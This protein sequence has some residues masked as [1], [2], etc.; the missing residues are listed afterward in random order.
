MRV[1]IQFLALLEHLDWELFDHRPY[2]PALAPSDYH[3]F[4]CLKNW[5]RSQL[6]NNNEELMEGIKPCLS[7]QAADF[8]ET[9]VQKLIPQYKYLNSGGDYIEK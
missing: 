4:I 2:S 7:S 6:F 9:G 8:F 3:L 5:L 1:R